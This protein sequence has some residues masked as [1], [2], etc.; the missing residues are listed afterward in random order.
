MSDYPG[1][2][3]VIEGADGCGKTTQIELLKDHFES[4]GYDVIL[5]REP[6]GTKLGERI[7][8]V[9]KDPSLEKMTTD[10][11]CFLFFGP[12]AQLLSEV[13][14]P[15]VRQGKI[16]LADRC[17]LST[18]AYQGH[19]GGFDVGLIKQN[20]QYLLSKYGISIDGGAVILPEQ[21]KKLLEGLLQEEIHIDRFHRKNPEYHMRVN[22]AYRQLAKE[23]NLKIIPYIKGEKGKEKEAIGKMQQQMREYF[24]SLLIK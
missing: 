11:E 12:R 3:F 7:R 21:D 24:D 20:A 19:A 10:A 16:A 18:V 15:A 17:F 4:K 9:L 22:E 1:K 13:I 23:F 2:Y 14:A 5:V 6:G 8:E